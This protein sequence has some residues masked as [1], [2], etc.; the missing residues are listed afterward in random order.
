MLLFLFLED[1]FCFCNVAFRLTY[2]L[3]Y[4][5]DSFSLFMN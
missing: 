2:V 5:I 3:E 1:Y 4:V